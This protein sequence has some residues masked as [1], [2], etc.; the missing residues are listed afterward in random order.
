MLDSFLKESQRVTFMLAAEWQTPK[1]RPIFT[2]TLP[3]VKQGHV[4]KTAFLAM[5]VV[6]LGQ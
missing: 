2:A 3:G 4:A 5:R 6:S 1:Q